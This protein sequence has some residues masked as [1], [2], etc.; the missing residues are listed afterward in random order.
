MTG[1]RQAVEGL[2]SRPGALLIDGN[3]IPSGLEG[4][5]VQAVV[6]GD[7]KSV[8]IAAASVLA[9]VRRHSREAGR[10]VD[11][12]CSMNSVLLAGSCMLAQAPSALCVVMVCVVEMPQVLLQ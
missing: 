6:G 2:A 9:K 7:G 1:M 12:G 5:A 10:A 4:Y 8:A 11:A 3:R